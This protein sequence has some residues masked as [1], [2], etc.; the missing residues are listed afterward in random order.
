MPRFSGQAGRLLSAVEFQ[1]LADVPAAMVWL[2]N[3]LNP[4]TRRSYQGD[5]EDFVGF[6]GIETPEELRLVN[7]AHVI[8]WRTQLE[9]LALAAAT[10]RRKMSAVS[11][12]F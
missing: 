6:C 1:Q 2:A 5:L 12:L 11:S 10:V 8:A 7:R 4:N 9:A 3:I